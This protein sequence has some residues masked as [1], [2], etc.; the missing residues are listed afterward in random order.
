MSFAFFGFP[1]VGARFFAQ[2][3]QLRSN[4]T[5]TQKHDKYVDLKYPFIA[6][7]Q[8]NIIKMAGCELG[9]DVFGFSILRRHLQRNTIKEIN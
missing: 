9:K 1:N 3:E 4:H 2:R 6:H 8:R 5:P 7:L